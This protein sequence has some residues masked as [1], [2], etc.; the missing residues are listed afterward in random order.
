[1]EHATQ[2]DLCPS[3]S[4]VSDPLQRV[5]TRG[6]EHEGVEVIDADRQVRATRGLDDLLQLRREGIGDG[7]VLR[8]GRIERQHAHALIRARDAPEEQTDHP[9]Q[10][11]QTDDLD[12]RNDAV[13]PGL[14]TLLRRGSELRPQQP[15]RR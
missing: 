2:R 9:E 15:R 4:D 5:V 14:E 7:S 3:G 6:A 12:Q 13:A 1:M 11:K 8:I 10:Q